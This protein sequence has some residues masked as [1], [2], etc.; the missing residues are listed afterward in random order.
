LNQAYGTIFRQDYVLGTFF[1]GAG[2]AMMALSGFRVAFEPLVLKLGSLVLGVYAC[3]VIFV[4]LFIRSDAMRPA[5]TGTQ[6]GVIGLT[7]ICSLLFAY[8]M[9]RF[10]VTSRFVK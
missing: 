2:V 10:P 9:S 7:L 4:D 1:T 6:I 3:H 8:S 5:S